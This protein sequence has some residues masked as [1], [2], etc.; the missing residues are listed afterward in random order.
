MA[1]DPSSLPPAMGGA[2]APPRR[3]AAPKK[4]ALP[5][6]LAQRNWRTLNSQSI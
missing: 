2:G 5:L 4:Q 3:G 6:I 1:R